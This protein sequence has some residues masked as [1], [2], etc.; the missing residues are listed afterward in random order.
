MS[1]YESHL[2]IQD[3]LHT[4]ITVYGGAL[5][6][7]N[8]FSLYFWQL[9]FPLIISR[10]T[11]IILLLWCGCEIIVQPFGKTHI[12]SR[13]CFVKNIFTKITYLLLH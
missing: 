6:P 2:H 1:V 5:L 13:M 3:K 9:F 10:L 7:I 11:K 4:H 8:S 12:N